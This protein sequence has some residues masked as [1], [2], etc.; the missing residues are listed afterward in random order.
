[1]T[2]LRN[3]TKSEIRKFSAF[4]ISFHLIFDHTLSNLI[5]CLMI[6]QKNYIQKLHIRVSMLQ[7]I[8]SR[9]DFSQ[10]EFEL[11]LAR[12]WI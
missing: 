10:N 12:K 8:L 4:P 2:K 7:W 9:F 11:G 5:V 3:V 6:S 1:M